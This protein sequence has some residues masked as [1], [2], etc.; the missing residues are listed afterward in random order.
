MNFKFW[1]DLLRRSARETDPPKD[2]L[3]QLRL[4]LWSRWREQV[5]RSVAIQKPAD[6]VKVTYST[7][8]LFDLKTYA[9]AAF[10]PGGRHST[11]P[12]PAMDSHIYW[13]DAQ[14]RPVYTEYRHSFNKTDWRGIYRYS[15]D[16]AEHIE[17][18]VQTRVCSRYVRASFENGQPRAFQRLLINGE[19]SFPIW[20]GLS[21]RKLVDAIESSSNNYSL[22]VEAY[23]VL[24]GK[25]QSVESYTAGLGSPPVRATLEYLYADGRLERIVRR[26]ERGGEQT[27]F[28]A[29][30][31]LSLKKL[32]RELSARIAA[33]TIEQLRA[34]RLDS[35]LVALEMNYRSVESYV[36]V[37]IP[38]T[39]RD[40]ITSLNLVLGI[41]RSRWISLS[42]EEFAPV[43][44][45]FA[46]RLH[47]TRGWHAGTRMLREAARLVTEAAPAQVDTKNFFV[48]FAVDW[49]ME[50]DDL[51]N[52]L[53]QCGASPEMME[54][55]RAHGWL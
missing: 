15:P 32:S 11:H 52:I 19:G 6:A 51:P 35:P 38:A 41:D 45:D 54:G 43:I 25:V 42:E 28:A 16:E 5:G 26:S 50:G 46:E 23:D 53:Q 30:R 3:E 8:R 4:D 34:A 39:E 37:L 40:D 14:G 44:T 48:A 27:I 18:C 55:F 31:P 20:Q 1:R 21:A 22:S 7:A 9:P 36:P 33:R 2:R 10:R 13:L 29:R 12:S 24:D 47:K 17:W 49:E